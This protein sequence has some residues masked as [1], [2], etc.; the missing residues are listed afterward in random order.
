MK[1]LV[2]ISLLNLAGLLSATAHAESQYV[3]PAITGSVATARVDFTIVIP[4]TLFL[5]VGTSSGNTTTD[6][7]I[8]GIVYTVPAANVGDAS[9]IAGVGGDLTAGAV[10]VR[11]YGNGG[12]ISLNSSVTGPLNNGNVGE[13]IPWSQIN[14]VAGAL[15]AT[16][17]SF[18]N[19]AITHP[20]FNPGAGGGAGTVTTLTAVAKVVRVEGKWTYTYLNA[21]PPAAGT[22]GATAANNGRVTYTATQL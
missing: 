10:T 16:T 3:N 11:V 15:G 5:R 21:T 6:G 4:Q 2:L 19:A 20:A 18:T 13:N 12:N 9:V 22:Y 7:T 1:K 14:V 8:N 17:S